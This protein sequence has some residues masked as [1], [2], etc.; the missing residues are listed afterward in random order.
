MKTMKTFLIKIGRITAQAVFPAMFALA[1]VSMA[2]FALSVP[3]VF[4]P[5]SFNTQQVGYFRIHVKA[6]GTS[7]TANGLACGTLTTGVCVVRLGALPSNAFVVRI[8]MQILTNFNSASGTDQLGLGTNVASAA[9][10]TAVNLL[11][12]TTVHTGAGGAVAQTVVSAN[13]GNTLT[14]ASAGQWGANGGMDLYLEFNNSSGAGPAAGEAILVLEYIDANDG[15]C[16]ATPLG[17]TPTN[18]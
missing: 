8:T 10:A 5:R 11:A 16:V 3:A 17:S 2:A 4:A 1:V 15:D 6:N 13:A 14:G 18:C 9:P 12:A 7:V